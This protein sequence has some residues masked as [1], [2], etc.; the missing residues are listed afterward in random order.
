MPIDALGADFV[1]LLIK[2]APLNSLYVSSAQRVLPNLANPAAGDAYYPLLG[3][4]FYKSDE[5]GP[6]VYGLTGN[7]SVG[8]KASKIAGLQIPN[9]LSLGDTYIMAEYIYLDKVEANMFRISDIQYPVVQ[10]YS[11]QPFDSLGLPKLTAPLR[12]P[13]PLRDLY[14]FAQ[15]REAIAYNC[16]FLATRDLSGLDVSIAPWWPDAS[17][18]T[19]QVL[20][21]YVAGYATRDSEP[22]NS[23]QLT[24]EGKLIRYESSSP[25]IFRSVLPAFNQRKTPWINRYYYNIPFGLNNG[26][27]PP[28]VPSGEGNLDK[29]Q[30]VDLQLQFKPFRGSMNPNNVPRYNVYLFAQTYNIFRVYGGRGGLLFAY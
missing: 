23:V 8:T 17:G 18:L 5:T 19:T 3:S 2:F 24:Y 1:R 22:I 15:R 7:P 30:R 9:E 14:F 16:R 29:I 28:S 26:I 11:L 4:S 27:T 10:H 12:I 25:S 13:N 6:L 21:D 20:G